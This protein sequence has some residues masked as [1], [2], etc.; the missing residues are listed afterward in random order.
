[1]NDQLTFCDIGLKNNLLRGIFSY[2]FEQPSDIQSKTIPLMISKID[3]IAQAHSGTGKTGSF[4]ISMLQI[5]D[6]Q[7]NGVQGLIV[8]PTREL[9]LQTYDVCKEIGKYCNINIVLC[10]GGTKIMSDDIEKMESMPTIIIGTPGKLIYIIENK[11][12]LTDKIKLTVI[13]EADEMLSD[14]FENQMRTII[15]SIPS[16][17]NI[18][19]F[20]ATMPREILELA[21]K[22]MNNPT[23]ILVKNEDI[24]LEGIRQYYINVNQ[25]KY[26]YEFLCD[27]YSRISINQSIIYVNTKVKANKLKNMLVEDGFSVSVIHSDMQP[28]ERD[29]IMKEYRSG[30]SRILISTDLLA[31][32]I[33]VQQVSIV[34][35]YDLPNN[36]ECYIHRIGRSGRF[37]R[38]GVAINITTDDSLW[39]IE[40]LST[41]YDTKI[42]ELPNDFE[43]Y[44]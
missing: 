22:F 31:R 41:Y 21:K 12:L 44:I 34:I 32:G 18:C 7:L 3:I 33:D 43:K 1:M 11:M 39:K 9:A 26:K 2:G 38:K 35:N 40:E 16:T 10:I 36:K 5:I 8:S 25:E 29:S 23:I 4:T 14:N 24:S 17:T 42:E 15:T 20:S 30:K 13:D 19:L 27:I 37:G 28:H 6:E